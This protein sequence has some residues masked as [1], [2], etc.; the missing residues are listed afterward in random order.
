MDKKGIRKKVLEVRSALKKS[1]VADK[2]S[3][4]VERLV[5]F[6][7][8]RRAK[9]IMVYLDFRK[10]VKTESLINHALR[11]GKR[12]TVP[13]VNA[14]DRSM[15]PSL[16][17]DF[18]GDLSIGSY[19]ILEPAPENLRPV[20]VQELDLIVVPGTVFDHQGNRMGYG[21]GYY[22]RFIPRL[23]KDAVTVALAFEFQVRENF[24][25]LMGKYDQPV[26]FIVTEKQIIQ[27]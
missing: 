8:Y 7:P 20:E 13:V 27:C 18:P 9:T 11:S 12:V 2:S 14:V 22:D 19:G 1:E 4:I 10:E 15:T 24:S 5:S 16:L 23:R 6:E 26:Q 25:V 3:V 21:G 17:V